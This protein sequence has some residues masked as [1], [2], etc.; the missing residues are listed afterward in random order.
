MTQA[1]ERFLHRLMRRLPIA[2]VSD[3]GAQLAWLK[4]RFIDPAVARK[5]RDNL[6]RHLPDLPATEIDRLVWRFVE[7]VGRLMAEFSIIQRFEPARHMEFVGVEAAR[8]DV[9]KVPTIAL[10]LHL[11]NW[12]VLALAMQSIGI[13][14]ASVA[15]IP[16]NAAH[17]E[18]ADATRSGFD[19]RVLTPDRRGLLRVLS[20]LRENGVVALFPDEKR[21]DTMMGPLFGRNPHVEGNMAMAAKLARRTGAQLIVAYCERV[22]T[23]RFRLHFG[24][25]FRMDPACDDPLA[26]VAALNGRIEP[27]ILSHLE[28]WYY[29]DD[30]IGPIAARTGA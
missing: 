24:Q 2:L 6:R 13:P 28:Q 8:V 20:I 22:D 1:L 12:E 10:C 9:G 17:R 16:D 14:I 11:G 25:P 27:I 3:I 29:L 23:T 18:I 21:G 26:D 15:E 5:A 4:I 30:S 7:N 19:V